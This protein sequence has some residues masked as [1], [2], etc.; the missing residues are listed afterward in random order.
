MTKDQPRRNPNQRSYHL[1]DETVAM[2]D[3][4]ARATT[5][6]Q[7]AIVRLAIRSYCGA[8]VPFGAQ[9]APPDFPPEPPVRTRE[10]LEAAMNQRVTVQRVEGRN[11]VV[12]DPRQE[13]FTV[14]ERFIER[15]MAPGSAVDD[16]DDI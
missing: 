2:L 1:D 4:K 7:S 10:E 12:P 6:S 3:A 11:I 13:N 9:P 16:E 5:L 15:G 14:P 8:A